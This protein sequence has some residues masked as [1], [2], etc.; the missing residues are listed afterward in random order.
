LWLRN[1]LIGS[2]DRRKLPANVLSEG[3][4]VCTQKQ[5]SFFVLN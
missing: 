4:A 5:Y 1:R 3:L 2:P